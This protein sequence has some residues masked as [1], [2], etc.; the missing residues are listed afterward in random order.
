M[1]L[2]EALPQRV[3]QIDDIVGPFGRGRL[4]DRVSFCLPPHQLFQSCLIFVLELARIEPG[5]LGG[6]D[7]SGKLWRYQR[8]GPCS[9]K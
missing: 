5:L 3:H 8:S 2:A 9:L 6:E 7:M 4:F 1:F